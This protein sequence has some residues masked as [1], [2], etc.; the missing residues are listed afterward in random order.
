[1]IVSAPAIFYFLGYVAIIYSIGN[2]AGSF[3]S[4]PY[5][6]HDVMQK[7]LIDSRKGC[8]TRLVG[9]SLQR[10]LPP[11]FC[12]TQTSFDHLPQ[13]VVVKLVGQQSYFGFKLDYIEYDWEKTLKLY[14][15]SLLLTTI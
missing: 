9:K 13:D 3:S 5:I 11:N 12:I 1:V 7:E 10:A 14:P 8:K 15:S 4:T 2:I 6:I